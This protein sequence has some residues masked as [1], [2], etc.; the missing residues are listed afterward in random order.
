MAKEW[1]KV[2][3]LGFIKPLEALQKVLPYLAN[4][5]SVVL[6]SGETSKQYSTEYESTNIIRLAWVGETKN[7]MHQLSSKKI[8]VNTISPGFTLTP[9]NE[10]KVSSKAKNLKTSDEDFIKEST[11][12]T[13][14]KRYGEP[15][16]IADVVS[17]LVSK[18]LR[19][20]NGINLV[21]DGGAS[22]IY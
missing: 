22:L 11:K 10:G 2:F 7:L 16:E 15:E 12:H 21:V 19:Y 18:K 5:S 4:N 3:R 6:F 14:L 9:F 17:F 1:E 8:R 20:I 13:P